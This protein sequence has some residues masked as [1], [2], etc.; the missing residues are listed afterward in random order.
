MCQ[1]GSDPGALDTAPGLALY[2]RGTYVWHEPF[3][4]GT[5]VAFPRLML[6]RYITRS[7]DYCPEVSQHSHVCTRAAKAIIATAGGQQMVRYT[8]V[9]RN[10]W[11]RRRHSVLSNSGLCY[12]TLWRQSVNIAFQCQ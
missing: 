5:F 1:M 12:I 4:K 8:D 11:S 2:L 10:Y 7:H 6:T 9:F 3:G